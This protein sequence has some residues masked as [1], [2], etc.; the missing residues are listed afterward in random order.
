VFLACWTGDGN[1]TLPVITITRQTTVTQ[2]NIC[3][4]SGDLIYLGEGLTVLQILLWRL[5]K[6]HVSI[7]EPNLGRPAFLLF[8][9]LSVT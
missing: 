3:W 1:I 7:I 9:Y 4:K 5:R 2:S 8:Y 6:C